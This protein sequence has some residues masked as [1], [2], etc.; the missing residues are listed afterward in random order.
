MA[1]LAVDSGYEHAAVGMGQCFAWGL[2][3][4]KYRAKVGFMA[5]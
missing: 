4:F 5:R 2:Y 1:A 3:C